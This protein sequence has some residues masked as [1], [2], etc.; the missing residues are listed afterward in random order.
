M[1][2][3]IWP[4]FCREEKASTQGVGWDVVT[5]RGETLGVMLGG[6]GG[7]SG[8]AY[9]VFRELASSLMGRKVSATGVDWSIVKRRGGRYWSYF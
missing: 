4:W 1:G 9:L 8:V 6:A 7:G 2:I 5:R 3:R